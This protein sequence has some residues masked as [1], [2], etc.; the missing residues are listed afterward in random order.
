MHAKMWVIYVTPS[1]Y[2]QSSED[3]CV[4]DMEVKGACR[5]Q[6]VCLATI[7]HRTPTQRHRKDKQ[8][9]VG[10][11]RK[12]RT[13]SLDLLGKFALNFTATLKF[14][15][16]ESFWKMDF[17]KGTLLYLFIFFTFSLSYITR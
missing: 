14:K 4:F 1:A 5:K 7:H 11:Q 8:R 13:R 15:L 3:I 6:A 12:L 16:A 2:L 10:R 9:M 17:T